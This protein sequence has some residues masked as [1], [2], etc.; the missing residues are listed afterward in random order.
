MALPDKENYRLVPY[1][2][3]INGSDAD[4]CKLEK[5]TNLFPDAKTLIELGILINLIFLSKE[6][7]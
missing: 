7:I 6:K 3:V 1:R 5:L 2:F 4:I